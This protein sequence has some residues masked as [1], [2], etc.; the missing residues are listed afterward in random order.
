MRSAFKMLLG[1]VLIASPSL[2]TAQQRQRQEAP[3]QNGALPPQ[4]QMPST[5]TPSAPLPQ[6]GGDCLDCPHAPSS[7]CDINPSLPQCP[8][9]DLD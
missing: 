8:G 3:P 6:Q 2:A 7:P 4:H 1:F 5:Q 9:R